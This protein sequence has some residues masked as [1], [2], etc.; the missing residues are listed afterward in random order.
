MDM[1]PPGHSM[2]MHGHGSNMWNDTAYTYWTRPDTANTFDVR[3]DI[4]K[5]VPVVKMHK[6]LT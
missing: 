6:V 5:L 1:A 2:A 3:F 4:L